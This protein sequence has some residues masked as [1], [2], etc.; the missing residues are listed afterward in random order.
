MSPSPSAIPEALY[1]APLNQSRWEE[2][3]RLTALAVS[4]ESA[5][6][7]L[8]DF[9]N[10]H[11]RVSRQWTVDPDASSSY[12]QHYFFLDEWRKNLTPD[13]N[14]LGTSESLVPFEE[15]RRTEFYN[16]FLL[17]YKMPHGLFG[18]V[19]R[20]KVGL[21][22]LSVFRSL[23]I[24]DEPT[25]SLTLEACS[26]RDARPATGTPASDNSTARHTTHL[27]RG[28]G[29]ATAN[30][31]RSGSPATTRTIDSRSAAANSARSQ[32]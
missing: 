9:N 25:A 20:D 17:P 31:A 15:M 13:S 5:A 29:P 18:I 21:A 26:N 14:L 2:F 8:H 16:D 11:A 12:E 10:P 6:L 24:G 27:P 7:M 30:A 22:H 19:G 32:F 23:L 4:G 3:L 1:A 28:P